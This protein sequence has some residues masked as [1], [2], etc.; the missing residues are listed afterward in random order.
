M[1]NLVLYNARIFGNQDADMV[2]VNGGRIAYV[3]RERKLDSHR[4]IDLQGRTV[5]PG[6]IDS[7]THLLNLGLSMNRLDLS[8]TSTRE[9]A[10]E[11]IR[12]YACQS[13]S[14]VIVGY[15]WDETT[16][17]EKDYLTDKEL[18]LTG[19]PMMLY[20]KDM[21][22]AVLN[23]KAMEL[24]GVK[25]EGGAFSE[26]SLGEVQWLSRPSGSEV[27]AA[28]MSA[29][30]RAASEGI[31]T[32]RDIMELG[33]METLKSMGFPV[34]VLGA[35]YDR[36]YENNDLT[37]A[38]WWG[39]KTFL[40]GSI[41]SRS[42]AHDGWRSENLKFSKEGLKNHLEKFWKSG[43]PVAMHAIG[44]IAVTQA[45]E[46]LSGQRGSMR[47]SIEHFELVEPERLERIRDSTVLSSQPNFLQW[48]N[49]G[50]LYENT[51]GQ[52]WFGRDNPF[53]SILDAGKNLAFGS[54]CMPI[55]PNYGIGFAV[56][57]PHSSQKINLPEAVRAYTE[58]GA[59]LLHMEGCL[60]KI[61]P[62]HYADLVI[63]DEKFEED[64]TG[65]GRKK[66]LGT[67]KEGIFTHS[68]SELTG[69]S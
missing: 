48:S 51:L 67:L 68:S 32:V 26:E 17:G 46:A 63:Q 16:W 20:R 60:G 8:Q 27:H 64:L 36:E 2:A 1:F 13:K 38:G 30:A 34:R 35:L 21:H 55:G 54:D 69:I 19:R 45:V 49:S 57:S 62:G 10:L 50:G 9:E 12:E 53:R 22:M 5:M 14:G 29:G 66:P 4:A 47:N 33:T 43:M 3:G 11:K 37:D 52:K 15:G 59:F 42:A 44:E 25:K 6:F 41:G 39:I 65:L 61:E 23:N 28:L 18:D 56:N 7:H 31:T 40:D 58:G 24:A